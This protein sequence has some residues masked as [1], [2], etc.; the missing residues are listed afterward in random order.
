MNVFS[1]PGE[2]VLRPIKSIHKQISMCALAILTLVALVPP[3]E[4]EIVYKPVNVKIG[5]NQT[6][7]LDLNDDG[8]TDFTIVQKA[9]Y[10]GLP[11]L[12]TFATAGNGV[13]TPEGSTE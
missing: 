3:S 2:A 11:E 13:A 10:N 5:L 7:D 6:Y 8:V 4:A 12:G 9:P 1:K